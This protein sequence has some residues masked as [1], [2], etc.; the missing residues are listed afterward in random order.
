MQNQQ[1]QQRGYGKPSAMQIQQQ[2]AKM[3][4][5]QAYSNSNPIVALQNQPRRPRKKGP[6]RIHKV[7]QQ[8]GG[9]APFAAKRKSAAELDAEMDDYRKAALKLESTL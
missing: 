9:A 6:K 2:N 8:R 4:Q 7:I 5:Q 3:V 1:R